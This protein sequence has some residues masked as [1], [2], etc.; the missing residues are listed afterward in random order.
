MRLGTLVYVMGIFTLFWIGTFLIY[1]LES[2]YGSSGIDFSTACTASV[3]TLNNI[4][5]GLNRVGAVENF[6]WFSSPSLAVMSVLMALGR[7]EV[8]AIFVLFV[9]RFWTSE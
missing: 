1:T 3:A 7:L 2:Y 5:P 8:Y 9:P 4:G 6:G